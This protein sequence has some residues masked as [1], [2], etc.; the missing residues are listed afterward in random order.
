M[1]SDTTRPQPQVGGR[2]SEGAL[3]RARRVWWTVGVVVALASLAGSASAIVGSA[4]VERTASAA[5]GTLD[6]RAELTLIS[7][8][9]GTCPPGV[10]PTTSCPARTGDGL[11]R[12][13]GRVTEA[14]SYLVDHSPS[15]PAAHVRVLGY[16]VR[17][18]VVGKGEIHFAVEEVPGC[19]PELPARSQTQAFTI[20]GGTGRYAGASGSGR[21]ERTL[22]STDTGAAGV[23]TWIGALNVPGHEFDLTAPTISGAVVKTLRARKRAKRARVTYTVSA[24]DDVDGDVPVVCQPKSGSRFRIGRTVVRCSATD[25][26]ANTRAVRFT[27]TVKR[28]R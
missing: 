17:W 28:A 20:T 18:T 11:V 8:S 14:Y 13:L 7:A 25:A 22:G 21:V 16:P 4:H 6:L 10:S 26:S 12:G 15:C 19:I 5:S 3:G 27:V 1:I 23:E 24:R 9:A 2:G